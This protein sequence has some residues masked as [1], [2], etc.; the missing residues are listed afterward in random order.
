MN[1]A[2]ILHKQAITRPE[3]PAIIDNYRGRSR[4]TSYAG[5]EESASRAC[6]LLRR[7]GLQFGDVV[8]VF[9][10]MSAELYIVLTALFRLGLVAMFLDP[11]AGKDHM[12]RCCALSPPKALI[13][14][15][16]AHLLRLQSKALRQIPLKFVIGLPIP[17]TVVWDS[18]QNL[19]LDAEIATCTPD[20]PALLT[21][22]SGSTG[23]PK[24]ALRTHGF[25]IAQYQ[26]LAQSLQLAPEAVDLATLPIFV[27]ANLAS[28]LT[29]LIPQGDLRFPGAITASPIVAQIQTHQPTR[30]VASPAFLQRLVDYC[31]PRNLTLSSVQKIFSGGAPIMPKLLAQLQQLAPQA[32]ITLV[33]GSTEAEPIAHISHPEIQ[34]QD[35]AAMLSGRGLLAGKPVSAINICILRQQWGDPITQYTQ[36]ELA[37]HCLPP[38]EVGEIVVSGNHVLSGYLQGEGNETTKFKVDGAVWHRTGDAGYLDKNG[39]LWLMGRCHACIKDNYGIL[40]PF[41]V[42]CVAQHHP[43]I[44]RAAVVSHQEKRLLMVECDRKR[45]QVDLASLHQSLAW[46]SIEEIRV[47]PK[48]PVDRRHNAKIDYPALLAL[49]ERNAG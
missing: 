28:G 11:S 34:P 32:E 13:A 39:R 12:E 46:A 33:Y 4:V 10:P 22:T 35:T 2:T 29:S 24:A 42:E 40:Y 18:S 27:L 6:T 30:V 14:S 36:A 26:V 5:L 19:P 41:A 17:G 48:L 7:S 45:T 9:Y 15:T 43:G 49:L 38:E 3:F 47:Y 44:R 25:L 21:F 1:I 8:L 20:T 23:R 37:A 16:K 31:L